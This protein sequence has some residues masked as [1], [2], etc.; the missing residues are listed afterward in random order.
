MKKIISLALAVVMVI[1]LL[2]M[3][4]VSVFAAETDTTEKNITLGASHI[5]GAQA[6]NVYFGTYQQSSDGN[7]GY[8][9]DP[10]KWRVL[11]NSDGKLFLLADKNLDVFQYNTVNTGVTWETS[12]MRSWLNGYAASENGQSTDYT[13]DNFIKTAFSTQELAY[14]LQTT[15]ENANNPKH[16]TT[17]GN[18]TEDYVFL[19]SI[20]DVL[21][22]AYGF[23]DNKNTTDTRKAT[24]T[25]Y[26]AAGGK[27]DSNMFEVRV[28]DYW[29]LRSPGHAT[30]KAAY[31]DKNGEVNAYGLGVYYDSYVVRPA[32]N[33]N[34]ASVL[35]TSAA[36]GGKT[37]FSANT[38]LTGSDGYKLTM[39]DTS[40]SGFS[41][42]ILKTANKTY[43][44]YQGA[45]TGANEYI[46]AMIVN[47]NGEVTYYGSLKNITETADASGMFEIDL[48]GMNSGD[49][50][51]ILNEQWNGDY[52]TDYSSALKEPTIYKEI[53]DNAGTT[54]VNYGVSENYTVTIPADITLS[55]NGET[56][57][58]VNTS[59]VVV[60]YGK[61]L[62][63][64]VSSNNYSE[65]KWYLV[66]NAN[67][68]N[69]LEYSIKNGDDAVAS[70]DTILTV[71]AGTT[72]EQKV[73]L[74]AKLV[75]K[76][77]YSG[78]YKDTLTF[79]VNVG[80]VSTTEE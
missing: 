72:V 53:E 23:T 24:H 77:T 11:S 59:S 64:S 4:M 22:T 14:I 39:L 31:V 30:D 8:N 19:L 3:T 49:K 18:D 34:S 15:L 25:A 58:E 42:E 78:T 70:N 66:D 20:A 7:D 38:A 45:T 52:K 51:Y 1:T 5:K 40:R 33:L 44:K 80:A 54:T 68:S 75:D 36:K 47:A 12:T 48:S 57:V 6:S 32:F 21:N 27:L 55:A 62:T 69:K 2:P 10:I 13:S 16:D 17:G 71:A 76:A 35:F 79:S 63:V 46:T 60:E 26:V 67:A 65:G 73:T 56:D 37:A 28:A 50:V 74:K 41:A 9:I 61:Q 29:W 43:V